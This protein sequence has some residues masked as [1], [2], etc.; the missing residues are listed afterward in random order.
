MAGHNRS[1]LGGRGRTQPGNKPWIALIQMSARATRSDEAS[2]SLVRDVPPSL[3]FASRYSIPATVGRFACFDACAENLSGA[4]EVASVGGF[5]HFATC[6]RPRRARGPAI[7]SGACGRC[8]PCWR[9][10]AGRHLPVLEDHLSQGLYTAGHIVGLA[11]V[12]NHDEALACARRAV[13]LN[14]EGWR[15]E[16]LFSGA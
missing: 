12:G 1:H 8:R 10:H 7:G 13:A 16:V 2:R 5:F 15:F 3:I 6:A 11:F 4:T 9:W 14:Q